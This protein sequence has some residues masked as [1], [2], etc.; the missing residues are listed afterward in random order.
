MNWFYRITGFAET[1]YTQTQARLRVVDGRL[2]SEAGG[3]GHA[4][5]TLDFVTLGA[6]REQARDIKVPGSL[7]LGTFEGDVRGLH[8]EAENA[9][10]VF[11]VASQFNLL[12]MVGPDMTPEDGV[13]GYVH[14]R[15]QGPAC[16]VA[17]GAGTIWRNYLV[18]IGDQIGQTASCQLDGLADLGNALA[19]SIGAEPGSLWDMR[20]G[21]ALPK[22]ASLARIEAHLAVLPEVGR[23]RLRSLLRVGVHRDVGVTEPSVPPHM[24]VTQVYCAALPVAYAPIPAVEWAQFATLILE[25]AYEATMLAAVLNA[26][27]GGSQRVFLTRLGGGAFGNVDA[28]INA[29]ILRALHL[30]AHQGLTVFMVSY[31]PPNTAIRAVEAAWRNRGS[32]AVLCRLSPNE[33]I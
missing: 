10:A 21:Y 30:V 11:Q 29:A 8:R 5:G 9:R 31:G 13:T 32:P 12:E 17:A 3:A 24:R 4:I 28:W 26:A 15:T 2:Q 14:D 18:P 33:G 1:D 25:A 6:L 27:G 7:T 20:N 22:R 23:D 19:G 16:A